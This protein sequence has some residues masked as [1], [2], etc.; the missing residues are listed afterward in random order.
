[1][2][3]TVYDCAESARMSVRSASTAMVMVC[4]M[5]WKDMTAPALHF[6]ME[7]ITNS[8][9]VYISEAITFPAL[10]ACQRS[11]RRAPFGSPSGSI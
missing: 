11:L 5:L 2:S 6:R 10:H 3:M 7:E 9:A 1:M 8:A 4:S